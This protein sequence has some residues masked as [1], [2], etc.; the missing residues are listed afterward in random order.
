MGALIFSRA[1]YSFDEEKK[2]KKRVCDPG[3]RSIGKFF[4]DS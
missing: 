1:S 2:I 4:T 3:E